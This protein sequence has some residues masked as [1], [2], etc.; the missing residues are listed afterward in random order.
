MMQRSFPPPNVL[1]LPS[2][3]AP[4]SQL[5]AAFEQTELLLRE[6]VDA[7]V[8]AFSR[9]GSWPTNLS[10]REK[11][12][13]CQ[14]IEFAIWVALALAA[15]GSDDGTTG[16]LPDPPEHFEKDD[17][18]EWLLIWA[19]RVPGHKFWIEKAVLNER[20]ARKNP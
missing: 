15:P 19:W 16:G 4:E 12:F 9:S 13:L 14:R 10:G 3:A 5:H 1:E 20:L 6:S 18:I 11:Y 17:Q 8:R 7:A 2:Q